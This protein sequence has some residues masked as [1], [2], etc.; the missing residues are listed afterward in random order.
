MTWSEPPQ[1]LPLGLSIV[2]YLIKLVLAL[3]KFSSVDVVPISGSSDAVAPTVVHAAG[4]HL[5]GG[6]SVG[7]ETQ[8]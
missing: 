4:R 8:G 2:P 7:E 6:L 5:T 3:E 1:F